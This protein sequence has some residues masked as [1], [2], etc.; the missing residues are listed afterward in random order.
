MRKSP[1]TALAASG[2][3]LFGVFFVP[4]TAFADDED[5]DD[6]DTSVIEPR[7]REHDETD[8]EVAHARL[9]LALARRFAPR[10]THASSILRA[11]KSRG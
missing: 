11:Q 8:R 4:A 9:Y 1:L 5:D 3:V 2:L 10:R 6:R 7:K